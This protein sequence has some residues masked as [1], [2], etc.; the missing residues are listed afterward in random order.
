[1]SKTPKENTMQINLSEQDRQKLKLL[2]DYSNVES[3]SEIWNLAAKQFGDRV[4][5]RD[6][7]AKPEI[8]M[9]YTQLNQKIQQFAA[10]LQALGV[11]AGDRVS[12]ISDNSPHWLIADQG[13]IR[14]GGVDVVRSSQAERQELLFILDNSG[15]TALV[16]ENLKTFKKLH[17]GIKDLPIHL[18]VLLSDEIPQTDES[19][20]I[21][22]FSQLIEIGANHTLQS[23]T[24]NSDTLATLMYTSGTTGKPK[25]VMLS[26]GNLMYQLNTVGVVVQPQVGDIVLSIL[27]T[28]H[29]YERT[30]EYFLFSQGCTQVYTNL[31]SVKRDLKEFKPHYMMCVPRL[32]ESIYE[33]VQKQFR[34]QPASKQRLINNLVSIS[35]KYIKARRIVQGLSLDNLN[36]SVGDRLAAS[37]QTVAL[38]PFHMLGE[39]LVYNKVREATGGRIKQFFSGGGALPKHIDDFFEIINVQILQGY[40]LTETSPVTHGRRQW[41][42]VRGSSGQPIPGTETKIVDPETRKPLPPRERGLVLLRGPQI[43]QG[44][45]HNP[46]ATAKAIDKDGW[47]DSGDLGWVTPKNDLVLTGRAKDTIVL[48]NGEN[49]EPQPIE[50]ACLRSPY[51]DQIM[52][53][54]QDQRSIGALIVPNL[55]ALQKWCETQNLSLH[56][57]EEG[58]IG[59]SEDSV[60]NTE[61]DLESK[62]IQDLFRQE[63][64][65]EV[66]NRPGYRQDDRITSFK[67]ILEPF[68]IENGMMT[69]TMKIRRH[70]VM[71]RYRDI[72]NGMFS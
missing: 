65:R 66:Q 20:K 6:P 13:I 3:L 31:R 16:V 10:G 43:M 7:H 24:Q 22:N 51:I 68:S 15:S 27:P 55:A 39:R 28:W 54:G 53:V 58:T 4:A 71:E 34:E 42:N 26:H 12:L 48:T 21:V 2:V 9:T 57:P 50:D 60:P 25:G 19:I 18:I 67:L 46:E 37:I 40:G 52:L 23:V 1:M 62:I 8:I 29:V 11:K 72:I 49:I 41:Q 63:L 45:Y 38:F 14:A 17:E 69:Q 5:L 30:C 47:F 59:E 44:Y 35:E 70:V 36:P 56:L 32:L 61:V 33:G 64:N